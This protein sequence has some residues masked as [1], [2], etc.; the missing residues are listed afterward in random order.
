MTIIY[1]F[2]WCAIFCFVL[3]FLGLVEIVMDRFKLLQRRDIRIRKRKSYGGASKSTRV[4]NLFMKR[5]RNLVKRLGIFFSV[6]LIA[7][8]GFGL[9][10]QQQ[11]IILNA[12]VD[13]PTYFHL[14]V[15]SAVVTWTNLDG[16]PAPGE[17]TNILA[18]QGEISITA[19]WCLDQAESLGHV[20][21]YFNCQNFM[22]VQTGTIL[23][24]S[25]NAYRYIL[26]GALGDGVATYAGVV[27][28]V[29]KWESGPGTYAGNSVGG[30]QAFWRHS[31]RSQPAG[32]YQSTIGILFTEETGT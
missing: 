27:D 17:F 10:Q 8:L 2:M 23:I 4:R 21:L 28:Y 13:I 20:A 12:T 22:D 7:G 1:F 9:C 3:V 6:L 19:Q 16:Y 26:T 29:K 24:S 31:I 11:E 25:A 30:M 18:D 5:R 14:N 15:G 32:E